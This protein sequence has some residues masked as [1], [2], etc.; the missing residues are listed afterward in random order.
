[1]AK[2]TLHR[3]QLRVE[4]VIISVTTFLPLNRSSEVVVHCESLLLAVDPRCP[5]QNHLQQC[6]QHV[7]WRLSCQSLSLCC[8]GDGY[9]EFCKPKQRLDISAAWSFFHEWLC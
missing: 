2:V 7:P 5:I 4:D 9:S 8:S 6:N 3:R 1:M